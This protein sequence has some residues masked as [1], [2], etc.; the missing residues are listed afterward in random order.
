MQRILLTA[1]ILYPMSLTAA[2]LP[3]IWAFLL[4]EQVVAVGS[5]VQQQALRI[6]GVALSCCAKVYRLIPPLSGQ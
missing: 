4:S 5:V 3:I 2:A 6:P 1:P